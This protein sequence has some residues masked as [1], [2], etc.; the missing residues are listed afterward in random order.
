MSDT[1]PSYKIIVM[2]DY[3]VGKTAL[4]VQ[5]SLDHFVNTYQ[6]TLGDDVYRKQN[7]IDGQPY[8]LEVLDTSGGEE[9]TPLTDM[10]IHHGEGFLLV[11]LIS[12]R[13]LF[14]RI[15]IIY[16]QIVRLKEQGPH[17]PPIMIMGN[18]CDRFIAREVSI[19]KGQALASRLGCQF[20]KTSAFAMINVWQSYYFLVLMIHEQ[21]KSTSTQ[22]KKK[23]KEEKSCC[24]IL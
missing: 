9:C 2:G 21:C 7:L 12:N 3:F 24:I 10:W 11:Y 4:T 22:D 6:P 16:S 17:P 19:N 14:E 13:E 8:I 15:K 18:K 5:F 1:I 20:L 23:E